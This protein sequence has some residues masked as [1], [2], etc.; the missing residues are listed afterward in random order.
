M[1]FTVENLDAPA[2]RAEFDS[3]AFKRAYTSEPSDA[4]RWIVDRD[5]GIFVARLGGGALDR[6]HVFELVMRNGLRAIF[7]ARLSATGP[8]A[9]HSLDVHWQV[10]SIALSDQQTIDAHLVSRWIVE[11]LEQY[12]YLGETQ[13]SNK[14]SVSVD[15]SVSDRGVRS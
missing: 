3:F 2:A 1:V 12:G 13:Y 4:S 9:N 6:P 15:S 7:E 11:S 10:E 14:V 5:R 8:A